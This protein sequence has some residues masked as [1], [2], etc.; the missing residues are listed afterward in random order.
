M[1]LPEAAKMIVVASTFAEGGEVFVL[2][3]GKPIKIIDIAKKIIAYTGHSLK[4]NKNPYGDIEIKII[5]L[6]HGE[7]LHEELL[8]DDK[9]TRIQNSKIIVADEN[10]LENDEVN[11]I[12]SRLKHAIDKD[13][14]V[15]AKKILVQYIPSLI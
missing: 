12:L 10:F 1:S 11:E 2:D 8:I 14:N 3:M 9:F 7:K 4:D 5:G 13:D 15:L 6:R